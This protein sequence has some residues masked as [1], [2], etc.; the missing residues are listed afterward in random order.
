MGQAAH[1]HGTLGLL[2]VNPRSGSGTPTADE[3]AREAE[4]RGINVHVLEP[5]EDVQQVARSAS[6]PIRES[7]AWLAGTCF[8]LTQEVRPAVP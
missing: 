1:L 5:G 3:L 7:S 2:I 6:K 4:L 8:G